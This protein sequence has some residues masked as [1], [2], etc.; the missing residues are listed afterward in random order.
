MMQMSVTNTIIPHNRLNSIR[1][2]LAVADPVTNCIYRLAAI[3]TN[4]QS[5]SSISRD[6]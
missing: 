1:E 4:V 3:M 2:S 6:P 5:S